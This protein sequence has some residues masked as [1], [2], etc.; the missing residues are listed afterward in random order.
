MK[1]ATLLLLIPFALCCEFAF[2]QDKSTARWESAYERLLEADPSVQKKIESGQATKED[3]INWLKNQ[4]GKTA[5]QQDRNKPTPDAG[6][7]KGK[8]AFQSKLDEMVKAG[9]LSKEDA[10][11][12]A[13]TMNTK[14]AGSEE[15]NPPKKV[16]WDAEYETLMADPTARAWIE[17]KQASKAQVIEYLKNQAGA[18]AKKGQATGGVKSKLGAKTKTGARPGSFNF[19]AIVIG[20]LKSKDIELGEMEIDVDYVIS[21]QPQLNAKLIGTRVKLVGVSGQF[22]D[23]L[24]RIKRGETIKVRTGDFN[25]KTGVLGFGYKFHVLERTSPFRPGDFG[26]PPNEFRGFQGEIVGKVVEASGYEVLLEVAESLPAEGSQATDA[27]CIVGKRI[28]IAGFFGGH[29][30]AYEAISAGD[31]IR[32]SVSHRNKQSDAVDVTETLETDQ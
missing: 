2:A 9:K 24:L 6:N 8:S 10:A 28:R 13:A 11:N 23:S 12:L 20:R 1:I 3:V 22:L 29:R 31:K 5:K 26:V 21:S 30:D 27:A 4:N 32:V 7:L 25:P 18:Q 19:Y 14:A 17:K 15:A 16:D